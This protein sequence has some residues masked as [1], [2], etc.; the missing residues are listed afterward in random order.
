LWPVYCCHS[1]GGLS[2]GG[3]K[4]IGGRKFPDV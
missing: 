1:I 2:I 3:H 4:S